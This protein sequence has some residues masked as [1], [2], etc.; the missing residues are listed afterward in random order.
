M[1]RSASLHVNEGSWAMLSDICL[2]LYKTFNLTA[3]VQ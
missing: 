2:T 3:F 1:T